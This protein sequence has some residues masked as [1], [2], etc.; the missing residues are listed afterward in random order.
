VRQQI[1][2]RRK[3]GPKRHRLTL[4]A[5][6]AGRQRGSG[7]FHPFLEGFNMEGNQTVASF[8]A[9]TVDNLPLQ[10]SF[11]LRIVCRAFVVC[12]F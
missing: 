12:H 7:Y 2:F 9:I 10:Q 5:I 11:P 3:C 4:A 6:G 8:P 1:T